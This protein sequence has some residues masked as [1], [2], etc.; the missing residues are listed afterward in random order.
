MIRLSLGTQGYLYAYIA[1]LDDPEEP[2]TEQGNGSS[3]NDDIST[4]ITDNGSTEDQPRQE[5]Q[6]RPT[7]TGNSCLIL[8]SAEAS[9]EQFQAFRRARTALE[10]RFRSTLGLNWDRYLGAG[11]SAE[12][13][14]ILNRFCSQ[15]N[16][17]H[18]FY[19]LRGRRGGAPCVNQVMTSPFASTLAGDHGAQRRIWGHYT[20]AALRL[21]RGSSQEGRVFSRYSENGCGGGASNDGTYGF[22]PSAGDQEQADAGNGG[23]GRAGSGGEAS[24]FAEATA[25]FEADPVHSLVYEIGATETFVSL[26]GRRDDGSGGSRWS[27]AL[28]G[29]G[30]SLIRGGS[31]GDSWGERDELHVCF[32]SGSIPV[33]QAY[34]AAVRLVAIIR[35]DREWL[36]LT[37]TGASK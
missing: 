36:F 19:C 34:K 16:A 9:A 30:G 29:G 7:R 23:S 31:G 32:P 4:S 13:E 18:F 15:L 25:I 14:S 12:R 2:T 37:G 3:S 35:R 11:A 26:F 22:S 33:E 10:S 20:R 17:L 6:Q 27:G 28:S 21:R 5:Q 1:F 24:G 8:V